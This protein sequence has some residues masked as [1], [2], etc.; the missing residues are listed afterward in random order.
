MLEKK[1]KGKGRGI[2]EVNSNVREGNPDLMIEVDGVRAAQA[3]A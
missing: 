2:K 1:G 3:W